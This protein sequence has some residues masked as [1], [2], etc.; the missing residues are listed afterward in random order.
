MVGTQFKSVLDGSGFANFIYSTLTYCLIHLPQIS[1][2]PTRCR[3]WNG[4]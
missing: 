2:V 4:D 1:L 3:E